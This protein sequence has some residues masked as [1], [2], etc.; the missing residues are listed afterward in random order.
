M[1][2]DAQGASREAALETV[3]A[4]VRQ[5]GDG[6]HSAASTVAGALGSGDVSTL[7]D[8]YAQARAAAEAAE[9]ALRSL[10]GLGVRRPVGDPDPVIAEVPLRLMDTPAPRELLEALEEAARKGAAVDRERRWYD[11]DGNPLGFGQTL[12]EMAD[13]LRREI[14]GMPGRV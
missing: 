8:A 1:D 5:A 3:A 12:S 9:D 4:Y 13:H 7:G 14:F 6:A 11:E 2:A 10:I